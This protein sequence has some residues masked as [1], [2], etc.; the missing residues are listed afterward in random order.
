MPDI[1]FPLTEEILNKNIQKM[2]YLPD[3]SKVLIWYNNK[4]FDIDVDLS[5]STKTTENYWE[6]IDQKLNGKADT[7]T[8]ESILHVMSSGLQPYYEE[9][10]NS[11]SADK[12]KV[13]QSKIILAFETVKEQ[14]R[15]LFTDEYQIAHIAIPIEG[16]LEILPINSSAFKNWYRMFIFERNGIVLDTATV[17]DTC[18]LASAYAAS[19]KYGSQI[20]LNLRTAL[21][22]DFRTQWVYDLVNKDW[23]FIKINSSGWEI[24]K[25]EIIFRRYSNQKS[26]VYPDRNYES[27]VLNQLMTLV[28]TKNKDSILLLK[29]YIISVSMA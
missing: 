7:A 22:Y 4:S 26:Q 20:P 27:N 21:K 15:N 12:D 18:S 19:H 9:Y 3:S 14:A 16:H 8:K 17:N 11:Q 25:D 6:I 10:V 24:F 2:L 28:N 13:K 29:C 5:D 23:E 1:E